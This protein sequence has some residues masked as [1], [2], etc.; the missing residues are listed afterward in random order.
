MLDFVAS[1]VIKVSCARR[2]RRRRRFEEALG[3]TERRRGNCRAAL[4]W[5]GSLIEYAKPR[6]VR[7]SVYN[8]HWNNYITCP[9]TW[10]VFLGHLPELGIKFD[11]SHTAYAGQDYLAQ[12]RDWSDRFH[13]F[14]I[15]GVLK[16]EGKR[17]DD[18]PAGMDQVEW[19]PFMAILYAKKYAGGL[20]I[21]PHS[22]NWQGTLGEQGVDFTIRHMK[23]LL[24]R[25]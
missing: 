3:Q 6:G 10:K 19:G 5:L 4:D 24:F 21:E 1:P 12:M 16:I 17:F 22:S 9:D 23:R 2:S 15:M 7:V 11:P 8:C 18:P 20:S 13:H 25:E 14:H